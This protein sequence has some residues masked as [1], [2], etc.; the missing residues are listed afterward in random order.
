MLL[1][2][3]WI[4]YTTG[5]YKSADEKYGNPSPY[6]RK[7]FVLNGNIK[8][9][10]LFASA[11]GVYKIYIN[12]S[13]VG[14]DYLSPG[15]V[16]YRKKLPLVRYDVTD[17]LEHENAIGAVL[18]DGWAVGHLGSDYAFKR[19]GYSDRI[20]FTALIR[21]EYTDGRTE[22]IATDETWRASAGAIQRSD[23]YMGEYTDARLDIGDFSQFDY[24]DSKWDVAQESIFKFSRNLYLEEMNIPPI[25]VKHTFKPKLIRKRD[26]TYL[27]DVAQNISGVLRCVFKGESGAKVVLR[28]GEILSEGELY[29]ENLRG[30]EA[31]DTY[32]LSGD[33]EEVF[34]PLFTFHGF[35]YA[36]LTVEG[37]AEIIDI[38][39][40]AMYT[41][42]VSSGSFSCSD[43][44]VNKVY[45]NALWGQR[46]N[47]L[48]VPTDCPQRDE[49]LGWTGDAQIFCQ[50]AMFNM[51]CRKFFE[52]Y[53]SDVRDEQLGNGVIPA[54]APV[55]PVGSYA[56]T[57]YDASAGWSEAIGEIPYVHYKMYGDK[58]IIRD[59][60]PALKKLLDYYQKES[61]GY[62]RGYVGRYGD[63]LSLGK[64]TDLSVVSTLY[65]ARGAYLAWKLCGVIGDYEEEYYLNLYKSIK[66]AFLERFV[67][68]DGKIFSDTQS[69][70]VMAYSFGIIDKETARKHLIRKFEEDD[71]KL[72]TGF[73]GIRFLLPTLCDVGCRDL[74]YRLMTNTEFPGWGYSVVNGATTIWERWD[75]YTKSEGIKKGMNSFNHYSLGSCTEWMYMY[76]LGIRPSFEKAGC[77]KVTF[78]PYLDTSGKITFANGYYDTDFGRINTSWKKADNS[79]FYEVTLPSE[80]EHEFIFDGM[81]I[82]KKE[83]N[84]GTYRFELI[85]DK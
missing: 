43:E 16:N 30:A 47:F 29:T 50:S 42:L 75:S 21:V 83:V 61:P 15:W 49:R 53:L 25:V 66:T 57:G 31:T 85:E 78:A 68:A 73:L 5:E 48:N 22:E 11:L 8:K 23:I 13:E 10:T 12:G 20:E 9:A 51:D 36:E 40:E 7:S 79:Y 60:L 39:A 37:N 18:G 28:H 1:E 17:M 27:Y 34:R 59:N 63:W 74:A 58:K 4:Y 52:K 46:D 3:K 76:C 26:N 45:N 80:I 69:A 67:D 41:D 81:K 77:K 38:T 33:G 2:S 35:R 84:D 72:T 14:N 82:V 54:V 70:Y 6:F 62:I 44:I 19:N 65:Y 24:D 71:G 64:T 32:I 55:P 56:Y